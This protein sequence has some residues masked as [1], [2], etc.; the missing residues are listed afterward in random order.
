G[1]EQVVGRSPAQIVIPRASGELLTEVDEACT[2]LVEA[3]LVEPPEGGWRVY[4][5]QSAGCAPITAALHEGVD[6]ITPVKPTGIAKSLN[7]GDPA[8]GP[9]ALAA[10]R[11]TGGW[12]E[13]ADD[14]EIREGIQLLGRR[15]EERRVGQE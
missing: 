15:S 3:G 6:E 12:M 4:G 10:V 8:A 9:Y 5:A 14:D 13:S 11:R 7:I 2:E 1:A